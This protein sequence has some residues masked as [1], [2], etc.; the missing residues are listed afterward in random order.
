MRPTRN[1]QRHSPPEYTPLIDT[2]GDDNGHSKC[3]SFCYYTTST[4]V[5]IC[6]IAIT[7][8]L[9]MLQKNILTIS[10]FTTE[11]LQHLSAAE[12]NEMLLCIQSLLKEV[13]KSD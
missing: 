12:F 6:M 2:N 9:S 1:L 3:R 10:E 8:F 11:T 4:I 5:A 13:C 7:V